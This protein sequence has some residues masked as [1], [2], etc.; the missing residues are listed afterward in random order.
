MTRTIPLWPF[1]LYAAAS[2]VHV[3]AMVLGAEPLVYPT[4]LLLMPLLAFAAVWTLRGT[5]WTIAASLIVSA[6]GFSWLGDGASLFFPFLADELPAMLA[7]FGIAH[8]LYIWLFARPLRVRPIP[9]WALIYAVWWIATLAF[10]WPYLGALNVAVAV[11][12][13]VLGGTAAASARGGPLTAL[14]GALFLAS[15]TI[16]AMRLFLP[17]DMSAA[18]AGFWVM[19]SYTTAQ[20]LLVYGAMRI[21]HR[22]HSPPTTMEP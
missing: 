22:G 15:D 21:L 20:G 10:L 9:R 17:A 5:R 14:G 13:L 2:V 19:L 4:K 7:C 8:L 16:L 12:G 3:G 18:I 6:L 1:W 11:Y